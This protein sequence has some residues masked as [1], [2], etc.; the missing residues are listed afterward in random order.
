M[1]TVYILV[2]DNGTILSVFNSKEE[3]ELM[4]LQIKLPSA[5]IEQHLVF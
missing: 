5:N 3:A 1:N 4:A 2:T